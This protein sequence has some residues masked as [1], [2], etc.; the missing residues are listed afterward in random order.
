MQVEPYD[1]ELFKGLLGRFLFSVCGRVRMFCI[2]IA[3]F[4]GEAIGA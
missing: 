4:K 2:G 1:G 3:G